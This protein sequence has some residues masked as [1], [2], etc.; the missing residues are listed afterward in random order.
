[1]H[2]S[3]LVLAF[4]SRKVYGPV[5]GLQKSHVKAPRMIVVVRRCYKSS[6]S[7]S[8]AVSAFLVHTSSK[9]LFLGLE[10]YER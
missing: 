8:N 5:D 7:C 4:V 10:L 6:V 3:C 1:M 9:Y 2:H